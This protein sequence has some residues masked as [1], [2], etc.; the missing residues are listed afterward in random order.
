M[1]NIIIVIEIIILLKI[2][3]MDYDHENKH[4]SRKIISYQNRNQD[5]FVLWKEII[6]CFSLFLHM[7]CCSFELILVIYVI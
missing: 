7:C 3:V 4:K 1:Y 2:S 6:F 5:F